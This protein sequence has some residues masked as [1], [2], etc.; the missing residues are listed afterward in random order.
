MRYRIFPLVALLAGCPS[1]SEDP[2]T[3]D[4][5]A[6]V[7]DDDA[8]V[9]DDDTTVDDDDSGADDD[10]SGADDDDSAQAPE[11]GTIQVTVYQ[12]GVL[13]EGTSVFTAAASGAWSA[14]FTTDA[15]G[16]ATLTDV[17][18]G[19][20][21]TVGFG[22]DAGG[23]LST[24]FGV[25]D[26]DTLVFGSEGLT[27]T[28]S[29][30][31]Y[32]ISAPDHPTL[33]NRWQAIFSCGGKSSVYNQLPATDRV[34]TIDEECTGS[35][36]ATAA[37]YDDQS[38]Y[39][40][41]WSFAEGT[42]EAT[43][44]SPNIEGSMTFGAWSTA[45]GSMEATLTA[46]EG[47]TFY[48]GIY[49]LLGGEF[50]TLISESQTLDATGAATLSAPISSTAFVDSVVHTRYRPSGG[51]YSYRLERHTS[52]PAVGAT[53]TYSST[54]DDYLPTP[55]AA[56]SSSDTRVLTTGVASTAACD[57]AQA[58]V[59]TGSIAGAWTARG[60]EGPYSSWEFVSPVVDTI[61]L[62]QLDPAVDGDYWPA[63]F[64]YTAASLR[65]LADAA[66]TYEDFRT[67]PDARRDL[68]SIGSTDVD[69]V[70]CYA[71]WSFED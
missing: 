32:L 46:S 41:A 30:G 12:G 40:E 37:H 58:G 27:S 50:L 16:Q 15:T 33:A 55:A 34:V 31:T 56:L 7:D 67:T 36:T 29:T 24:V 26:G 5:D 39:E 52:L 60:G 8:T 54:P 6:T 20:A 23:Q 9:D 11:L 49:G 43:G 71:D 1:S 65:V 51:R 17:P 48:A 62:P 22:A 19:G 44:T 42:F 25:Q 45:H 2:V 63:E 47:D 3:D 57:G 14:T 68:F 10:D 21:V 66:M 28:P 13:S 64:D 69:G 70:F 38:S 61:T 18:V 59:L 4:D 53:L 35:I